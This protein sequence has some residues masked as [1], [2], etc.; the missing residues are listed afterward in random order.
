[1]TM[2]PQ[3]MFLS[4]WTPGPQ[5]GTLNRFAARLGSLIPVLSLI[6]PFD[7]YLDLRELLGELSASHPDRD[8]EFIVGG[9]G[10]ISVGA[11][12]FKLGAS[13]STRIRHGAGKKF[14]PPADV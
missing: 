11:A 5:G 9:S 13:I 8:K 10:D 12:L 6:R 4:R 3:P 2:F 1:M 7:F 14:S